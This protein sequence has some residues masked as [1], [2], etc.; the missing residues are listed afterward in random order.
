MIVML[1][2]VTCVLLLV[3][4]YI[5]GRGLLIASFMGNYVP[6]QTV[7]TVHARVTMWQPELHSVGTLHAVEGADLAAEIAGLVTNIGF[8]PG[9]DVGKGALLV[10]LRDDSDRAQLAALRASAMLAAQTF[11]RDQELIKSDAISKTGYDT[12]LA[13]LKNAEAQA[14]AQA[15]VVEK[16]AIRAPFSGRVGIRQVDVGQYVAAGQVLV[17]LQQLDPIFVDFQVPQQ[18]LSQ[19]SV[20]DRVALTTD[21]FAGKTFGGEIVAFDPKVDLDTRNV[22]VRA[23]IANPG[24]QLLPGM[25]ATAITSI[26][27]PSLRVTLPQTALSFN[28]YG[29]TVFLAIKTGKTKDGQDS[30]VARQRFVTVGETRGDQ[31][32]ILSGVTPNDIVISSGQLKLKNGAPIKINNSVSLPNEPAPV[33]ADE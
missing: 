13:T 7:S 12:A 26:G 5:A 31:I 23:A 32:A 16:K 19:L 4:G 25:F 27:R 29:D 22:R 30:F 18:Q 6:V 3:F 33:P 21:A 2:S 10:Q 14:A 24:K 20:G 8:R 1:V 17:T 11:A 9:Q 28:P 15:A